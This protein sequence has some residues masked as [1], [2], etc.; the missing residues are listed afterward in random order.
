MEQIEGFVEGIIYCNEQ[1]GYTVC[2]LRS[3]RRIITAVGCMP[4]LCVG[5]TVL[6]GGLWV[7]HQDYGKQLKV[8]S[9]ERR[10]PNTTDAILKY[11]SSGVIKGIGGATAKKLVAAFG[12]ATLR[13]V[14]FEALRHTKLTGVIND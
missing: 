14:Q 11:L 2:E 4:G 10:L 13:V 7:V 12:D 3:G 1:N 5:E 9:C 6:V 8:E